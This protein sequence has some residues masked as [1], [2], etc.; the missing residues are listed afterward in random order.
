MREL[1]ISIVVVVVVVDV[2]LCFFCCF[3]QGQNCHTKQ[4]KLCVVK[5]HHGYKLHTV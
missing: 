5:D 4:K 1:I 2:I 3:F